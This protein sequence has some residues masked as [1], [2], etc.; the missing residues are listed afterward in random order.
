MKP[1]G[2]ETHDHL[3]CVADTM[4]AAETRCAEKKLHFTPVRRRVLE[5]LLEKHRALG[6]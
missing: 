1:I 5:L 3:G 2:F 6:A 4:Q